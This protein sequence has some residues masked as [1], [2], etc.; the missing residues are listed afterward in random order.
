MYNMENKIKMPRLFIEKLSRIIILLFILSLE[1]PIALACSMWAATGD[2]LR[3]GGTLVGMTWDVPR[4]MKGELRFVIPEKGSRYLG[5]FPLHVED[6]DIVIAG[7]NELGLVVVTASADSKKSKKKPRRGGNLVETILTSFGTV[8]SV[9]TDRKIFSEAHP[10]F[11]IIADSTKIALIQIGSGGKHTVDSTNNGLFYQTNHYTRQ[12]L[13]K[14]NELYVKNSVLRLNR[15]QYLIV[16]H[17]RPFTL[18]D[19]LSIAGDRSNGPD[20]S[21]WRIGSSENKERTLASLV[22]YL[23][24]NSPPELYFKLLNPSSNEL[25]YEIKLDRLFWIEG[26]E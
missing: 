23:S 10:L 9:L 14:E 12:N 24:E 2:R 5:L 15:L 3:D 16:N 13:L 19:F 8:D 22:V 6:N 1:G 4:G 7:I 18:D 26:T 25:G 17:T 21:I 11:L 20:N